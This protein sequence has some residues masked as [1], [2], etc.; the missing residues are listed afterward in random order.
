MTGAVSPALLDGAG[1]E[2]SALLSMPAHP[3]VLIVALHGGGMRASY[4]DTPESPDDTEVRSLLR[5]GSDDGAAVLA[6][7]RPGYGASAHQVPEGL[8]EPQQADIMWAAV[9]DFVHTRGLSTPVVLVGHSTGAK[10]AAYMAA[11]PG[12][13]PAAGLHMGGVGWHYAAAMRDHLLGRSDSPLSREMFWG[14][15][16]WYPPNVAETARAV[17]SS[18]PRGEWA[19]VLQWEDELPRLARRIVI[20]TQIVLAEDE[21]VWNLDDAEL[22]SMGQLFAHAE[23]LTLGIQPGSGHNVSLSHAAAPYHRSVVEFALRQA[24]RG[25]SQANC[26]DAASRR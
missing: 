3:R 12:V 11:A 7:D 13:R 18:T 17:S 6:V 5:L 19:T 10:V 24:V 25:S 15:D 8:T 14:R 9:D 2:M 26:P 21:R 20:P 4:F 23:S 22:T 1:I 16:R